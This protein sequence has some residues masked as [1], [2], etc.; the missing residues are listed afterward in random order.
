MYTSVGAIL[1]V[2][3][4]GIFNILSTVIYEKTR[5]IAILRSLGFTEGD[6]RTVF[7]LEG[8]VVGV[9]GTLLGWLLGFGITEFLASLKFSVE[10]FVKSEGFVLDRSFRHYWLVGVFALVVSAFAA[11]LPARRAARVRPVDIIRSA[12]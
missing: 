9:A 2:A 12:A 6:M 10:G 4:F 7:V 5:D 3:G 1:V 8:L 11:F